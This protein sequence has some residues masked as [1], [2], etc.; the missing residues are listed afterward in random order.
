MAS[1][2]NNGAREDKCVASHNGFSLIELMIV[3]AIIAIIAA[4]A[5]PS[6]IGARIAANEAAAI[7][8]LRTIHTAQVHFQSSAYVDVDG[9]GTGDFATSLAQLHDP[10]GDGSVHPI[11][12]G[13]AD[14]SKS[15]YMFVMNTTLGNSAA[16]TPPTFTCQANPIAQGWAGGTSIWTKGERYTSLTQGRY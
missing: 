14:G 3:V 16:G 15:G 9:D 13:L 12:S 5:I 10:L 2:R 4:F 8:S 1:H 6:L 11:D 7:Q